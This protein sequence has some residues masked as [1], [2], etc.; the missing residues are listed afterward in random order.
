MMMGCSYVHD[1]VTPRRVGCSQ[2]EDNVRP[3]AAV[4]DTQDQECDQDD[5][6][7]AGLETGAL[8]HG[9]YWEGPES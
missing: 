5:I 4:K 3:S 2:A 9:N 6:I 1:K 7:R 8:M